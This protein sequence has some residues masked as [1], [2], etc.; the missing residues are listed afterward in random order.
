MDK[1]E[2]IKL[3]S[4]CTTKEMVS[5]LKKPPTEREKIC[6]SYTSNEGLITRICREL[7]KLHSPKIK[8]P[9]KNWATELNRTFSKE[10][11]QMAK[12]HMKKMLTIPGHKANANQTHTKIPPHPYWNSYYQKGTLIHCWWECKLVPPL[13]K[14]YGGFLLNKYLPYDPAIPLLGIY[15]K[16]CESGY[17]RG[18][19][20]P[21]F[22]AALFTIAKLWKQPRCPT[23]DEWIKKMWYLYTMEFYSAI[24]KN[25]ILSFTSKWMKL[26]NI[27]LIEVSQPQKMKNRMFP[28]IC[29]L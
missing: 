1:W 23:T 6:C 12:T 7:K 3:K 16:E 18:T 8:E 29:G 20:T 27:I 14:Q 26:E 28:L 10:K 5:K 9:I 4:F 2:F 15:P 19:C 24:K 21:M 11:I 17:F 13:G 22:I 25:K